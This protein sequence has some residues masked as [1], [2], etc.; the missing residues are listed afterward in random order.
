MEPALILDVLQKWNPWGK[1][2][3]SGIPR[4]VYLNKIYP[5]M[6][7]KEVLILQGIR[8]A[9]KSMLLRQLMQELISHGVNPAQILYLN[10]EDYNFAPHL[11]VELLEQV[12]QAYRQHLQPAGKVY[13]FIDEVQ[14]INNWESWVRTYYDRQENVK[15]IVTGSSSKL[16][17]RESAT[18]MTGRNITFIIR[19]LSFTEYCSFSGSQRL[20]DYLEFG[21]FPEVVLQPSE[22]K[23]RTLLQQYIT[24]IIYKDVIEKHNI[25]N[26]K[27]LLEIALYLLSAAGG[28]VSVSRLAKVFGLSMQTISLYISYLIE[29]YLLYEVTWF[30]YSLKTRHDVTKLPKL[31]ASDN[32]LINPTSITYARNRG[33][34][35]ENAVLVH[36]AARSPEVHYWSTAKTEVDFI[37][38]KTAINVTATD[39]IP[40]REQAGLQEFLKKYKTFIP[41]LITASRKEGKM[42]PLQEFLLG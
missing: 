25:R 12:F 29:A 13:L 21:G 38:E 42:V 34:L 28:K 36:L 35:F 8:R 33:Q 7:N 9:G 11:R 5:F 3:E 32:G 10:L 1:Q 31:Y 23:K 22:L 20:Q 19:P 16:M 39:S 15:F 30:S 2:L 14:K 4:P 41:L 37:V 27:Q 24:D 40:E 18:V 6:D 26:A 17:G